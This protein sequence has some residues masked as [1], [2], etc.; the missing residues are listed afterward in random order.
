M[1]IRVRLPLFGLLVVT[2]TLILFTAALYALFDAAGQSVED[3][4]LAERAGQALIALE[5]AAQDEF[6]PSSVAAPV[7]PAESNDLFT[8]LLGA[9]GKPISS[10]GEVEGAIPGIPADVLAAAKTD[11]EAVSTIE[12]APGVFLR[13]H[14]RPWSRPDL[15]LSGYIAVAQSSQRVEDDLRVSRFILA[16]AAIFAFIV[17]AIAIWLVIGRALRPLKQLAGL[18]NEVGLTQDLGRRLPVPRANDEVRLLSESFNGMMSRLEESHLQLSG[19]LESQKRFVADASHELRTPLTTIRAN[20]DFLQAHPEARQEDRLAAITDITSE[21][22]RMSRLVQE[23]LTLAR[24]DGGFHLEKTPLNLGP[25]VEDV[26]RQ[27]ANIHTTRNLRANAAPMSIEANE[28]AVKQLLWILIDNAARHTAEGGNI[29]LALEQRDGALE[30][31]VADDGE[32]IPEDDL[33]RVF[34]RFFQADAARAAGRSGPGLS[35][36][37]WIVEEHGGGIAARNNDHGGATVLVEFP[38]SPPKADETG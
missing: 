18:T 20:A 30:L 17:A 24:A 37:S 23:L 7:D 22:E 3:D 4:Q 11:G 26:V 14:V 33:P 5:T 36:A 38:L 19:A 29:R 31:I 6:S 16:A 28:D 10:T 1:S 32:G 2:L 25:I 27:A 13:V 35:I 9:D 12:S 34:D 21:S 15:N 8:V